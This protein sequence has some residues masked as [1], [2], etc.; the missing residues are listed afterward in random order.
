MFGAAV[1][2]AVIV[3]IL[4][5]FTF[6]LHPSEIMLDII[7]EMNA[8]RDDRQAELDARREERMARRENLRNASNSR[9]SKT[10]QEEQF[11]RDKRRNSIYLSRK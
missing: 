8:R 9:V 7:E 3:V 6:G 2:T 10:A 1:A 4:C 11:I 5:V